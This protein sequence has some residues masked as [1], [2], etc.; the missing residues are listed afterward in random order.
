MWDA[1]AELFEAFEEDDFILVKARGETYRRKLQLV[2]T[3]LRRLD[4]AKVDLEVFLPTTKRDVRELV[5]R[6][7]A[8]A[9]EVANPHLKGLLEAFLGDQEFLDGF[10]RA[11]GGVAIHHA[12]LGGLLEHTVAVAELALLTADRYAN[13]DRDLLVTGAILH[14]VGKTESFDYSR[15]FR[16]ADAGGLV[17]HLPIG[18]RMV[19]ERARGLDGFPPELLDQLRHL[20]LSHHGQY[21]FGSPIL[22]ATAEAIA[23]HYLDNL[24]AKLNAFETTLLRDADPHSDWTEWSRVFGRRLFKR[25]V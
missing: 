1:T 6:L 3:D 4:P 24:D 8:I 25:R 23:L 11:P 7:R 14:D 2:V 13:L 5:E 21:D 18:V 9:G 22:P 17:G 16:Y 19:E 10:R 12:C 20:V 15:A